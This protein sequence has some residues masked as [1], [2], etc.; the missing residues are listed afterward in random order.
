[1]VESVDDLEHSSSFC[2]DRLYRS[3]D[4]SLLVS[5]LVFSF[6]PIDL[7]ERGKVLLFLTINCDDVGA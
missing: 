3:I 7:V 2:N 5:K 1:M 6:A 4:R